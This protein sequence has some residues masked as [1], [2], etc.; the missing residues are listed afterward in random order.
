MNELKNVNI[1]Y[2]EYYNIYFRNMCLYPKINH[3]QFIGE[4]KN[5]DASDLSN[6]NAAI[7]RHYFYYGKD[8][9]ISETAMFY[10]DSII[11]LCH[12]H[13]IKIILIGSPVHQEYYSKIPENVKARYNLEKARLIKQGIFVIDFTNHFYDEEYYLDIDHLNE[14]GAVIFAAEINEII[15]TQNQY[16]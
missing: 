6:L 12:E 9:G 4:Y 15:S 16:N 11:N 7:Q 10:L 8:A 3:I 2:N 14:K 1:D 5:F 13:Q